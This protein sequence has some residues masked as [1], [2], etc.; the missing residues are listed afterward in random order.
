MKK[1]CVVTATRA[2]YGLLRPVLF[3]LNQSNRVQLQIIVTG[4]HLEKKYGE[5]IKEIRQDGF[6]PDNSI[7]I[8]VNDTPKGILGTMANAIKSVGEAFENLKPDLIVLL[9]DRYETLAI[10]SAAAVLGIPIAHLYGGEVTYGAYDE[11]FRH[12][13]TKMSYYHFT[14]TDEYRKRVIQMGESPERVFCVG[15]LGVEN[16]LNIE[17]LSKTEL[18]SKIDFCMDNTL[19]ITFHPVTMELGSQKAQFEALLEA[20]CKNSNYNSLIT[21]SNAD[22]NRSELD[23]I[24]DRYSKNNN[25]MKVVDSL[26]VVK[27]LSAMK[28]SAG[29]VGNSS[30]GI[31]EAPS[32]KVGTIDI[33]NRQKGRIRAKSIIHCNPTKKDIIEA[34]EILNSEDFNNNLA[35]IINPYEGKETSTNIATRLEELVYSDCKPKEFFNLY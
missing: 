23:D 18:E 14:A 27:Y 5:T 7:R 21:R 25:K 9:G 17:L 8:F 31:V 30:S 2:E 34:L 28:Y 1:I 32:M 13:I 22:T 6:T 33:G 15:S 11:V 29:V 26:G 35:S 20:I 24:L 3:K 4:T 10:A 19:L 12:A 16:V